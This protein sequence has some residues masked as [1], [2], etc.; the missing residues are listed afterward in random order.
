MKKLY[1]FLPLLVAFAAIS[2]DT[3]AVPTSKLSQL[4]NGGALVSATDR[5]ATVR[6]GTT[7]VLTTPATVA[8]TGSAADLTGTLP[9]ASLP[10]PSATTLGGTRSISPITHDFLTGISTSGVPS[11]AQPAFTDISGTATTAQLPSITATNATAAISFADRATLQILHG[12]DYGMKCDGNVLYDMTLTNGSAVVSS[13]SYT[14]TSG[15]VGKHI[16]VSATNFKGATN[17]TTTIASVAGGN[18]TLTVGWS[19]STVS[20]TGVGVFYTTDD[21]TSL[22][23]ALDT[24]HTDYPNGAKLLLNGYCVVGAAHIYR[25][26]MVG[27]ANGYQSCELVEKPGTNA[28]WITSENQATLTGTGAN[29]GTNAN[30]PSFFGFEDMHVNGNAPAQTAGDCVDFYGNAEIMKGNNLIESCWGDGLHT[31]AANL[32]PYNANDWRAEEEGFIDHL[33]IRD[34]GTFGWVDEG[35]HDTI[36]LDYVSFGNGSDG[37]VSQTSGSLYAGSVHAEK[38]HVYANADGTAF[39]IGAALTAQEVYSDFGNTTINSGAT[40]DHLLFTACGYQGL[41]CL[42]IPSGVF[43]V[44]IG[45]L[46]LQML[47]TAT[48]LAAVDIQSGGGNDVIDSYQMST[49]TPGA[50]VTA[51]KIR[52]P[53]VTLGTGVISNFSASGDIAFDLQGSTFVNINGSG[54]GN[55][56]FFS[57]GSGDNNNS[58]NFQAYGVSGADT[59]ASGSYGANDYLN[60]AADTG[61]PLLQFPLVT[62]V[63]YASTVTPVGGSRFN[64]FNIG[65]QTG[66]ITIA[67]PS[68]TPVDGN[69]IEVRFV[70]N[71]TG[72][73]TTTFN[74]VYAFGTDVTTA[75]IPTAANSK[76]EIKF[77]YDATDSKWRAVAIAR[78]F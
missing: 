11:Q 69:Q 5:L 61:A 59:I 68:G 49:V 75:L 76:F 21:T 51:F 47:N 48:N 39:N 63:S 44:H 29:Y 19:A 30:V 4:S 73:Y 9:A 43:G 33:T 64:V 78:G 20:G 54:F 28:N 46:D 24:I 38:M 41:G 40:I 77:I 42:I 52:S 36:L 50:N 2:P 22:Q 72:G 37:F 23:S 17:V 55:A 1:R 74:S 70:I 62:S 8:G 25:Q 60:I 67:A 57:F 58:I 12:Q 32:F 56:T 65:T 3:G 14:F 16:N 18:A 66:N 34:A 53:F 15:D 31:E 6:N 35:P 27:C 7:D 26:Q 71:A 10:N 13:A 45:A